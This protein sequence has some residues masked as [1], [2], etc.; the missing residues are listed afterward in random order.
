VRGENPVIPD[1]RTVFQEGDIILGVV[2]L[3]GLKK[4]KKFLKLQ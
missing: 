3:S 1:E 4:V 2:R